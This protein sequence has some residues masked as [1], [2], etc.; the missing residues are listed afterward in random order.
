MIAA[1]LVVAPTVAAAQSSA[2]TE[3]APA[4][5]SIDGDSQLRGGFILPLVALVAVVVAVILLTGDDDD[6]ETPVTP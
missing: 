5:E 2:P 6:E 3:V 1:S 4:S